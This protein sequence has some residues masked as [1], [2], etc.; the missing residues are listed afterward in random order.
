MTPGN[1]AK[2]VSTKLI[3]KVVPKPCF[4]NTAK[5]GKSMLSIIVNSDI[6]FCLGSLKDIGILLAYLAQ[7][8]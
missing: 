5:G 1:Q 8:Q 4:K 6:V 3:K 7:Y 2:R